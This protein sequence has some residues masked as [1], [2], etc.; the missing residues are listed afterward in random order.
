MSLKANKRQFAK[1]LKDLQEVHDSCKLLLQEIRVTC[2]GGSWYILADDVHDVYIDDLEYGLKPLTE[3]TKL[4][5]IGEA[6]TDL[7]LYKEEI[8]ELLINFYLFKN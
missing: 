5:D 4:D 2:C 1:Y 3:T 8:H 6:F 7:V